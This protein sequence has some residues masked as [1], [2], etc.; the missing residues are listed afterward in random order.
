MSETI[1]TKI[2]NR[3][4]P[5]H[6]LYEDD[7][8]V[9]ILDVFPALSGQSLVIPKEPIDYLFDLP[10]ETY[11]HLWQVTHTVVT[12]IDTVLS[13]ERT[14]VVVE[15]YE[16]PHAHIKLYPTPNATPLGKILPNQQPGDQDELAALAEKIRAALS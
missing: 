15:G 3:E 5:G 2:I 6:F 9:V 7:H 11:Q 1:F 14:C 8:C 16:V 10:E 13:P 4:I 12:A